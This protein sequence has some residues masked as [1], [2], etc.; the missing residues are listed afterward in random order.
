MKKIFITGLVF[1]TVVLGGCSNKTGLNSSISKDAYDGSVIITMPEHGNDCS[2]MV[3]TG[4]GAQWSSKNPS[5]AIL[6]INVF[7]EITTIQSAKISIDGEEFLI[8][9]KDGYSNFDSFSPV[10]RNSKQAFLVDLTLIKSLSKANDAR[11][12]V[13]TSK[14]QMSDVI[15][16][17]GKDS[18]AIYAIQRFVNDINNQ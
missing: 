16:A 10:I 6:L 7:N 17:N 4:I 12:K 1:A 2:S 18:K 5:K 11:I 15:V 13:F 3:C 9:K 8:D 14:G